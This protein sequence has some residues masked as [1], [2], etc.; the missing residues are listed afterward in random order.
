M[1]LQPCPS[2]ELA[3][4]TPLHH[5]SVISGLVFFALSL[6]YPYRL[7]CRGGRHQW[8]R[9]VRH[10]EQAVGLEYTSKGLRYATA[11]APVPRPRD[12]CLR[13]WLHDVSEQRPEASKGKETEPIP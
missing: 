3:L 4:R 12:L 8:R 10:G 7:P 13:F 1:S 2:Y 5:G 6:V 9:H 11:R